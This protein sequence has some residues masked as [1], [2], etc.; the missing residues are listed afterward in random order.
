MTTEE[1]SWPTYLDAA[2]ES[3]RRERREVERECQAF[4]RFRKRTQSLK[5][6]PPQIEQI[7]G[8]AHQRF[9]SAQ[10]SVRDVIEPY[11][12]ETVM[13][14]D[15]Y[16]DVYGD[17]FETSISAEF[18]ADVLL[19]ISEAMSFSQVIKQRLLGAAQQCIDRR[20]VFIETLETESAMFKD[21]QSTIQ[22]IRNTVV[23]I[24]DEDL[25]DL[26]VTQL[27]SRQETLQSLT[28]KCEEW[29][30][31]RQEQIHVRRSER[32]SGERDYTTL[33]SYLYEPLDVDHPILA[34]FVEVMEIIRGREGH[35]L[36]MLG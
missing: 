25:R 8:G 21:A 33:C 35:I 28:R 7:S 30:Q 19:L 10:P 36:R 13:A 17:S 6:D 15:H 1:P 18:G 31:R 11:Y 22:T 24:D 4:R 2:L 27:T 5:T 20:R 16:D 23:E 34:T 29:L 3:V 26:S 14:V 12:R 32:S 9:S